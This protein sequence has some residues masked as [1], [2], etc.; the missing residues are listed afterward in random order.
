M[1]E[2]VSSGAREHDKAD[3]EGSPKTSSSPPLGAEGGD[4]KTLAPPDASSGPGGDG[5]GAGDPRSFSQLLAGAMASAA[6]VSSSAALILP[7]PVLAVPCYIAPAAGL[8]GHFAVTHQAVLA[9]VTAQALLQLQKSYPSSSDFLRNSVPQPQL[10]NVTLVP[11]QQDPLP[12]AGNNACAPETEQPP[13]SHQNQ[14]S[15]SIVVKTSFDDEK[16]S[17][18]DD[19]NWRKYGQK[20]VKNSENIRSYYKCAHGDCYVKKKVECCQDGRVTEIVYRGCHNHEPPLKVRSSRVRKAKR[21][22]S[23]VVNKNLDLPG[24]ELKEAVP[25]PSKLQQTSGNETLKEELPCSNDHEEDSGMKAQEDLGEKP[26]PKRR[27][28]ESTVL[29]SAPILKTIREPKIVLQTACGVGLTSDGYGWRKYGQKFVKGNPNPRS[30]Y[31]CTH[32]GCPVRK[33]VERSSEDAKYMVITYEGKHNHD[34]PSLKDGSDPPA[35]P[36]LTAVATA[37][38]KCEQTQKNYPL[39]YEKPTTKLL[40]D[41]DGKIV[42]ERAQELGGEKAIESAQTLLSMGLSSTSENVGRKN[43][44]GIQQPQLNRNCTLPVQNS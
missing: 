6:A 11:L 26:D 25:S 9:S 30:Y 2:E 29:F 21:G 39:S 27:V 42:N 3:R 28:S 18:G 44:E 16:E 31:R 22:A 37:M 33:H 34:L 5:G 43:S 24:A 32:I 8:S 12:V 38:S 10:S 17:S 4:S 41:V 35:T 20:Q 19:Y 36:L 40:P 13:S 15:N 7:V 1:A 23:C 14:Q